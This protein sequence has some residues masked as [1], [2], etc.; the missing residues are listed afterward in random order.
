M[1]ITEKS[2]IVRNHGSHLQVTLLHATE[3]RLIFEVS[4]AA[5]WQLAM[6]PVSIRG[7]ESQLN[8]RTSGTVLVL[9]GKLVK[10]DHEPK[11]VPEG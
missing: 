9:L 4:A 1:S 2:A 7:I 10:R 11:K 3:S 6:T 5:N 8:V